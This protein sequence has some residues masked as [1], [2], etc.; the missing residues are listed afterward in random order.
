M[1]KTK[2][3][4]TAMLANVLQWLKSMED[5]ALPGLDI[6]IEGGLP[7]KLRLMPAARL[8]APSDFMLGSAAVIEKRWALTVSHCLLTDPEELWLY[9]S[10]VGTAPVRIRVSKVYWQDGK[11]S[12]VGHGSWH[13]QAADFTGPQD[14]IVLLKLASDMPEFW[15]GFAKLPGSVCPE[16]DDYVIVAGY[17]EDSAGNY[18]THAQIAVARYLEARTQWRGAIYRDRHVLLNGMVRKYDSGAPL[19]LPDL[20]S[21]SI[22]KLARLAG[23]HTTRSGTSAEKGGMPEEGVATFLPLSPAVQAWIRRKLERPPRCPPVP[24][25]SGST[26]SETSETFVLRN[27][28]HCIR[29]STDDALCNEV[30]DDKTVTPWV[31]NAVA[32]SN[33]VFRKCERFTISLSA[34]NIPFMKFLDHS[35]ARAVPFAL[36]REPDG[37]W[38]H[39]IDALDT[40]YYVFA[41][42]AGTLGSSTRRRVRVEAFVKGSQR[43]RPGDDNIT[44]S[45]KPELPRTEIV[46]CPGPPA[47]VAAVL[48]SSAEVEQADQDDQ[49]NGYEKPR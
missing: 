5:S 39:G 20:S 46:V 6:L 29:V 10:P 24:P 27:A 38:F 37:R 18:P 26:P 21:P 13:P 47:S 48:R 36:T 19:F 7:D 12:R 31:L 9:T 2:V 35:G 23:L 33:K 32:S 30:G 34:D 1:S 49:A 45:Y 42:P 41:L 15:T 4:Q 44:K 14:Q 28:H 11:R 25:S 3:D 22:G 43:T 40:E 16:P 8:L 17:G